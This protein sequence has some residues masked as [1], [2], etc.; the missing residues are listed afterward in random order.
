MAGGYTGKILRANL[1]ERSITVEEPDEAFYRLYLGGAGFITHYLL[2]EMPAGIDP[3]SPENVLVLAN[4]PVTGTMIQGGARNCIG[5]KA[6]LTGA[7]GKAEVSGY[8]GA[9]LKRAGFDA[10]VVDGKASSPV[11]IWV[12]DGGAAIRDASH[13]WGLPTK[14]TQAAMREELGDRLVRTALIGPAGENLVRFAAVINDVA[15]HAAGRGGLGAVLG[16]KNL[17][18][19]AVRGRQR[20]E[21]ADRSKVMEYV[22]WMANRENMMSR[23]GRSRLL[24]TGGGDLVQGHDSGNLPIHNFRGGILE[25]YGNLTFYGDREKYRVGDEG[26]FA[27]SVLCKKVVEINEPPYVVDKEYGGPEYETQASFGSTCGVTDIRAMCKAHELC[28]AYGMDTIS[29]GVTVAFAM[30]C[31][32]NG[33]LT[34]EDTG[35]ID[36][37]FGNGEAMVKVVEMIAKR[38]GVGDLLAEGTKRAAQ[39]IGRGAE[40]FAMQV[41]GLELPMHEPRWRH[42]GGFRY[43]V[44]PIGADHCGGSGDVSTEAALERLK[45]FGYYNVLAANDPSLVKV[46]IFRDAHRLA[47]FRDCAVFCSFVRWN[48]HE[49]IGIMRAVTGWDYGEG[50]ALRVGERVATMGRAFNI[51]EGFTAADDWLPDRFFQTAASGPL[52][53]EERAI[54]RDDFSKA[55]KYYYHIMG[56]TP[57][58]IPTREKMEELDVAWVAEELRLPSIFEQALVRPSSS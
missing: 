10:I 24:G 7:L 31:F 25:G 22:R 3:L 38:E 42:A 27:C 26:C 46:D 2:K 36:L 47:L 21:V 40:E 5:A 39:R 34:P 28:A 44:N 50:E 17:K 48:Q 23:S 45:S 52:S 8:W 12:H 56:W 41:K 16:S 9:E 1:S 14:E 30:E 33:L 35:G 57:E 55:L 13:L 15:S 37:R 20:P 4:G 53:A 6:P 11:Y 19:I 29:C 18:G 54:D 49:T 32:E 51:R 58:G 43:A